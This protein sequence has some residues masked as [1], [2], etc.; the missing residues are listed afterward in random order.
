MLRWPRYAC[1]VF[2]SCA[3]RNTF[4]FVGQWCRFTKGR[5]RKSG[6]IVHP[7]PLPLR[8]ALGC[9]KDVVRCKKAKCLFLFYRRDPFHR[10]P[11]EHTA[12]QQRKKKH[13]KETLPQC[14]PARMNNR[15][16]AKRYTPYR[17]I[18]KHYTSASAAGSARCVISARICK[19][20]TLPLH[21][22]EARPREWAA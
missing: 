22:R 1:I 8:G 18:L 5:V 20:K 6:N 12:Q 17:T 3:A 10:A 15:R 7:L 9:C 2:G 19:H 4:Y 11:T 21:Q 13:S 16:T 14:I